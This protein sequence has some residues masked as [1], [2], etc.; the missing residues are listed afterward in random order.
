GDRTLQVVLV[1]DLELAVALV[2]DLGDLEGA[3]RIGADDDG[4][5]AAGQRNV[6][7]AHGQRAEAFAVAV[8][9]EGAD[10]G[11]VGRAVLGT[12]RQTGFVDIDLARMRTRRIL[13]DVRLGDG[14]DGERRGRL[15]AVGI[16]Q[17]VVEDVVL[18][19][20]NAVRTDR[21]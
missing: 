17:R 8:D 16:R 14:V 9:R 19:L 6:L 10:R 13:M 2:L 4:Q 5:A 21:V 3:G 12:G 15:V 20:G 18:A 11:R 1:G 7:A